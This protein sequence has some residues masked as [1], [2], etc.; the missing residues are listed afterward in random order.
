MIPPLPEQRVSETKKQSKDWQEKCIRA[1][2]GRAYSNLSG[3]RSSREHKQINYDLFNSIINLEDFSYVTKP[4]GVDIHDAIGNLPANFQDYNI[5]RSSVLQLVGEELK[6]PF[7]YK[8][9]STAGEGYN[10]FLE[11]RKASLEQ[12]YLS[13]LQN[14][15]GEKSEYPN[16]E[17]IDKYFKN[18][19]TNNIEIA[20]NKLLKHTEISLKLKDKFIKGFRNALISAEEVYYAGIWNNQPVLIPWN[21]IHFE[22]DKNQDT[23]FIEDCDWAVGRWWVDRGQVLDFWGDKLTPKQKDML[24]SAE[25]FNATASYGQSP[26]V[27]TTT[28][29][30]YNYT[31]TKI[32]MQLVTWKSEK[33]IGTLTYI[34]DRGQVQKTTVDENFEIPEGMENEMQVEWFWIP[35]TWEG[36]QIGPE[37]FIA[38]ESPYQFN[39]VDN[40]Y[41]SKLPFIGRVYSNLNSKPTS[42]VDLI[43]PYQYLYNIIW[44]RLELEFSK[45]KG[46]KFVMDMAQLPKSKGWTVEQ[47]MYYF[48]TLGIAFINSKEEGR[49][50]D[51]SS[52][53]KFNGFTGIDMSL[54]NAIQGYFTMLSKIEECVENITGI[55]RQRKGQ[56]NTSETVGGVERSVM[57]SNALTE[58]YFHEH[59]MVKEKVLEHLLELS[60]ICYAN[61]EQ[62]K[63][64]F[65]EFTREILDLQGLLL[66]DF[67]LYVNDSVR[68]NGILEQLKGLA[69]E[70][71]SSGTLEFSNLVTLV[72]SNST[73]EVEAAIKESERLKREQ[74]N[75]QNQTAQQ[76]IEST[77]RLEKEKMDREDRNKQLDRENDIQK[78]T[79][80]TLRGKD[81][82]SDINQNSIPD[83]MEVGKLALEQSREEF[84]QEKEKGKLSLEIEKL[85]LQNEQFMREQNQQ[86]AKNKQDAIFKAKELQLKEKDIEVKKKALKYKSKPSTKK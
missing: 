9:I 3:S 7:Q 40:P 72:K 62:G 66:T 6:R 18:T 73:A 20:A 67:G 41:K 36:V 37:I 68:E 69:K 34:N 10:Q 74:V 35:R 1:L 26:E 79:I 8:V 47:W 60:K 63:L 76:Q 46:K 59:S 43:K 64:V 71:I 75:A 44:Y 77:E 38:Y 27:I 14:V 23:D 65:D 84:N 4:Y 5:V 50:G 45:A 49:E 86:D 15:L 21:P 48:D 81:G 39:T 25:V 70:G 55:T 22:C 80:Q 19:Y 33:K 58:I 57:Q 24:R 54:T 52:V 85:K 16:P 78:V 29:P 32:L 28:Y 13:I 82:P 11:D 42:L 12:S 56:I 61:N 83:A 51:E 17:E 31:G 30:Q 53:S 2:V